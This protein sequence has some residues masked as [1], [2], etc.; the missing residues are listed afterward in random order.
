[1]I[2]GGL[3]AAATAETQVG[4]GLLPEISMGLG[5]YSA[6]VAFGGAPATAARGLVGA[7]VFGWGVGKNIDW[8]ITNYVGTPGKAL[9]EAAYDVG[10]RYVNPSPNNLIFGWRGDFVDRLT[11]ATQ[12]THLP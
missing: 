12:W 5:R 3:T 10:F 2:F 7:G 8:F 9:G 1:V 4:I 6:S 11:I